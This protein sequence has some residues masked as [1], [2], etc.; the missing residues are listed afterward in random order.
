MEINVIKPQ[1]KKKNS[2]KPQKNLTVEKLGFI[3]KTAKC[4]LEE[5]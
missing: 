1:K 3:L 4:F 2:K 5:G